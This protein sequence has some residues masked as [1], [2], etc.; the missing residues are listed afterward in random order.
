LGVR[1]LSLT[2]PHKE[3]ALELVDSMSEEAKEIGAINTV[4]NDGVKWHGENT[5]WYGINQALAEANIKVDGHRALVLGAG[6]AARAGIYALKRLGAKEICVFN[7]TQE[8]AK[9]IAKEFSVGVQELSDGSRLEGLGFDLVV[10]A[11]PIGS[12]L[13]S[14]RSHPF[15]LDHWPAE[16]AVFDM[17]TKTTELIKAARDA[18]ARVTEGP[19]MLLHQAVKQFELFSGEKAPIDVMEQALLAQLAASG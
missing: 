19:R 13:A 5:D 2:I 12:V 11:T 3:N 9:A 7:R 17:V 8:R 4:L 16:I 6:G 10:N 14:D 1:G 18:G 15:V